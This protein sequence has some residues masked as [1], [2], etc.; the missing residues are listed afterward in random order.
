MLANLEQIF[1]VGWR[2]LF[3][4]DFRVTKRYYEKEK[5]LNFLSRSSS[6]ENESLILIHVEWN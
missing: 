1:S 4:M 3:P 6:V 2:R 5:I